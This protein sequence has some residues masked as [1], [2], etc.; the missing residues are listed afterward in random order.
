LRLMAAAAQRLQ[1][2]GHQDLMLWALEDNLPA[3]KFYERL[4]G[5]VIA[6]RIEKFNGEPLREIAYGWRKLSML[7]N[8]C[9]ELP[10]S[11]P[12]A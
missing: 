10:Q 7:I 3:R 4:G 12:S 9:A 5:A 6:E 8:L 1:L 2:F 11:Q